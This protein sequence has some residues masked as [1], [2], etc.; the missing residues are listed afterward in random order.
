MTIQIWN[1]RERTLQ[2]KHSYPGPIGKSLPIRKVD[3]K[4]LAKE[5]QV[6]LSQRYVSGCL[7]LLPS[8]K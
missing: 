6:L 8:S 7:I 4:I 1:R 5:I 3:N 2:N